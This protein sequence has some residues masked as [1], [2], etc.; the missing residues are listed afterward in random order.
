M[1]V[2]IDWLSQIISPHEPEGEIVYMNGLNKCVTIKESAL[3]NKDV[4]I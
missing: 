2:I 4:R 3:Q 1:N